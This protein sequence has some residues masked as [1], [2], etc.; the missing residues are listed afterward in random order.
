MLAVNVLVLALLLQLGPPTEA[1]P[2]QELQPAACPGVQ[3][4]MDDGATRDDRRRAPQPTPPRGPRLLAEL[5]ASHDPSAISGG[6]GPLAGP[7]PDEGAATAAAMASLSARFRGMR[8]PMARRHPMLGL[9]EVGLGRIFAL[10]QRASTSYHIHEHIRCSLSEATMCDR[11]LARGRRP[12][13]GRRRAR[14]RAGEALP[15][16]A[17]G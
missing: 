12:G 2:T 13:G 6:A 15:G 5:L 14:V 9:H 1:S 4:K 3:L 8:P 10:H 17:A 11:T 7:P 16:R